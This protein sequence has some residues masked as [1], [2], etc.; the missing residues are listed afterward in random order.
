M[1]HIN[2]FFNEQ[3]M[4][5]KCATI[6][7]TKYVCAFVLRENSLGCE[8]SITDLAVV[9]R[10][11]VIRTDIIFVSLIVW[12]FVWIQMSLKIVIYFFHTKI[13]IQ[14]YLLVTYQQHCIV[15]FNPMLYNLSY[16]CYYSILQL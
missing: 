13:L 3:R 16:N 9:S 10:L 15:I 8:I 4:R 5:R 14:T 1:L 6:N 11:V 2:M 12:L 7:P